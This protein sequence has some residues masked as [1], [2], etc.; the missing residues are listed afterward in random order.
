MLADPRA[1]LFQ[2]EPDASGERSGA[3]RVTLLGNVS[4]TP[5]PELVGAR[6][7]YLKRYPDSKYWVDFD[8]F[9][10]YEMDVFGCLL[11][12]RRFWGNGPVGSV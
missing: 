7:I 9:F 3:S 12:R 5:E 4:K 10:F 1:S 6:N 2:V 11:L 8:D